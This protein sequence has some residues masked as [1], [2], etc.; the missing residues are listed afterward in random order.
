MVYPLLFI[1]YTSAFDL[2][3]QKT[4]QTYKKHFSIELYI[5]ALTT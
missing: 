2:F 1:H 4:L 3:T 5:V